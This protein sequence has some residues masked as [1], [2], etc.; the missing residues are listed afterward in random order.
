[1][2][3]IFSYRHTGGDANQGRGAPAQSPVWHPVHERGLPGHARWDKLLPGFMVRTMSM[4]GRTRALLR[5]VR[6]NW[7]GR[8]RSDLGVAHR[9]RCVQR[10]GC[11]CSLSRAP[12]T[13]ETQNKPV[14]RGAKP[15]R[16]RSAGVSGRRAPHPGASNFKNAPLAGLEPGAKTETRQGG[17]SHR[18]TTLAESLGVVV[19]AI[20]V[21]GDAHCAVS[22]LKNYPLALP[23]P[24]AKIETPVEGEPR[25]AV[26]GTSQA[27]D[28]GSEPWW[29]AWLSPTWVRRPPRCPD[30]SR[31]RVRRQA[32]RGR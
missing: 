19:S 2:D 8:R 7:Q 22:T 14:P 16:K 20:Q 17:A 26:G 1:M 6:L 28:P 10:Q 11:G 9:P 15:C 27:H 3:S 5:G 21:A 13:G 32:G 23:P 18:Q 31:R 29:S 25:P 24:G 12:L 30:P 4:G